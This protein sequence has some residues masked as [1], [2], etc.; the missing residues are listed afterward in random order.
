M[1]LVIGNKNYSSWSLRPWLLL[2]AFGLDFKEINETLIKTDRRQ[3]LAKYSPSC[4]VPVLIDGELRI[5]DSLAICEYV[6]EVYLQDSGWPEDRI[7]RAQARMLCAEMHA[8]FQ[9]LRNEMPMNC[10]AR[11]KLKLSSSVVDDIA[12]IDD[13]WS[14]YT[15]E[16]GQL[17]TWMFGSFSIADCFFAPVALRFRTYGII[18]SDGAQ[19]YARQL[20]DHPSV[21]EWVEAAKLEKET[22]LEDEVGT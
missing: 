17:G 8:G 21:L 6:S 9:A 16:H 7:L 1:D 2:S 4:K 18:L 22:L 10:R 15:G 5:W 20:L 19:L 12:R 11:R 13:I 3:R 14:S